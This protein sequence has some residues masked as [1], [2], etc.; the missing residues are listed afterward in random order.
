MICTFNLR[1]STYFVVREISGVTA[2]QISTAGTFCSRTDSTS[3]YASE[4]D[5]FPCGDDD[6]ED[7]TSDVNKDEEGEGEGEVVVVDFA[8]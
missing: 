8:A 6:S 5:C 2:T 4:D 3:K 7:A 1:R